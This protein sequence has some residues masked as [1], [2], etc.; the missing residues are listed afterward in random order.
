[1]Y[2]HASKSGT[3]VFVENL[4]LKSNKTHQKKILKII[5]MIGSGVIVYIALAFHDKHIKEL[6]DAVR[7][8]GKPITLYFAEF[9]PK[10][11]AP[12]QRVTIISM[13]Y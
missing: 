10:I 2:A 9:N 4:L 3:E 6:Q 5:E 12:L 11:F 13:C 1:M 8:S 7:R